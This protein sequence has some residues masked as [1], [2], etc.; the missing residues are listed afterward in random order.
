MAALATVTQLSQRLSTDITD[1]VRA[2]TLLDDASAVVRSY[3]GQDFTQ[4]TTTDRVQIK[5]GWVRLPQ[6]TDEIEFAVQAWS[7]HRNQP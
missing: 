6:R 5:R 4:A 1:H 2:A 3:T 7:P